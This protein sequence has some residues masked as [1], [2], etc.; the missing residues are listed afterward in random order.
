MKLEV[1]IIIG[2]LILT[3]VFGKRPMLY[4]GKSN[5]SAENVLFLLFINE[6]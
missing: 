4:S 3:Y 6:Y 2:L 5:F 1:Y